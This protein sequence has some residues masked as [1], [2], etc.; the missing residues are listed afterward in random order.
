MKVFYTKLQKILIPDILI[1]LAHN[2]WHKSAVPLFLK[3]LFFPLIVVLIAAMIYNP[4]KLDNVQRI[5]GILI[6]LL[7]GYFVA[8]T[9][10]KKDH[11]S[12]STTKV[13]AVAKPTPKLPPT[14]NELE[15]NL[16]E[17]LRFLQRSTEYFDKGYEDEAK[18]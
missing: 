6:L 14:T 1:E 3:Y 4:M 5:I 9:L 15:A 18:E 16:R 10:Y 8:H 11:E 2:L 17:Q 7:C 13:E 12:E